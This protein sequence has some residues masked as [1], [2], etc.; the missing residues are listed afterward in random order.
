MTSLFRNIGHLRSVGFKH[1]S[2]LSASAS[3]FA[4]DVRQKGEEQ[5]QEQEQAPKKPTFRADRGPTRDQFGDVMLFL[6]YHL[7]QVGSFH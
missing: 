4:L 3:S 7:K 5:G 2:S 6:K 1:M